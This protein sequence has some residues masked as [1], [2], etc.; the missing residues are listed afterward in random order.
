MKKSIYFHQVNQVNFKKGKPGKPLRKEN[1]RE[2]KSKMKTGC[3]QEQERYRVTLNFSKEEFELFRQA[4]EVL[5]ISPGKLIK[6]SL[7]TEPVTNLLKVLLA[8]KENI[9]KVVDVYNKGLEEQK[10]NAK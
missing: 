3:E 7:L 5:K 4:S 9:F 1:E 10:K 6:E 2:M 8:N